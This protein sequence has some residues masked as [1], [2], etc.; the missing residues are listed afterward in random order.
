MAESKSGILGHL[1]VNANL[2]VCVCLFRAKKLHMDRND[3]MQQTLSQMNATT[4]Q[5]ERLAKEKEDASNAKAQ[6]QAKLEV[7]NR[8]RTVQS[9]LW[10]ACYTHQAG[11][12]IVC[13]QKGQP[14][15]VWLSGPC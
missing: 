9:T 7:R 14:L 2:C 10:L 15:N 6:T 12:Q 8:G 3:E 1:V 4:E 11:L 5:L 13:M